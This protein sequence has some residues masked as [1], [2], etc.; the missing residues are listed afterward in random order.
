MKN[1]EI[2]NWCEIDKYAA[3]S[4]SI[5]HN[6]PLEKNL[7]DITKVDER[8]LN[9]FN[10]MCFGSPCQ[11]F[12]L[13]GKLKGS[14]WKCKDCGEEYN[15]LTVHYSNRN[16]CPNCGSEELD[17]TRSSLL[18]EGLRIIK[19]NKPT[20][21]IYENVK[22]IVGK[23]FK[24]TFN[25]LLQELDEYGYNTYYKVLNAKDY[26]V[27]QNRERVYLIFIKKEYDNGTFVFPEPFDNGKRLRDVLENN[28]E[29]KYY[30]TNS[31]AQKLMTECRNSDLFKDE[32]LEFK[33]RRYT[34]KEC[35]R[36][37]SFDD[38]D[39]EKLR[40][41]GISDTQLYKVTGNSIVVN[42]LYYIFVNLY[43]AMPYLFDDLKIGSYFSGIG[44]FEK[45]I[46]RLYRDINND[47]ITFLN[48]QTENNKV[49]P[50]NEIIRIGNASTGKSQAGMVYGG[51]A[52]RK[53]SAP[54][55]KDMQ[56]DT[57]SFNK[58]YVGAAMRGR[59]NSDGSTKQFLEINSEDYS[60]ALTTVQKDT[61]LVEILPI[62]DGF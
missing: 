61:L 31:N 36:L 11:D 19:E 29:E 42:V 40:E 59:Y 56:L 41:N 55:L 30:V 7:G 39:Y 44:A 23:Q 3:K 4:Y 1:Y 20:W 45:A 62:K 15:P 54:V 51:A 58:R 5:I 48:Y 35:F 8:I 2:V 33:I 13:S 32:T 12:S 43:R 26:G 9:P 60:N 17:K 47:S 37:M 6:Q 53:Q 28:I 52:S 50:R 38:I 18:V 14:K 34:P 25:M 24:Q 49:Y 22:N 21:G 46:E 57:S 16:K 10:M 27:P